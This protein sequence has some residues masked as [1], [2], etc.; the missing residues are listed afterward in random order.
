MLVHL[1]R[2]CYVCLPSLMI[3]PVPPVLL[4]FT[5]LALFC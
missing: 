2:R 1:L 5:L 3:L 4:C